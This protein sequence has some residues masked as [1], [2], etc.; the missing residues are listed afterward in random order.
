MEKR[1]YKP[2]T[3]KEIKTLERLYYSTPTHEIAQLLD[4]PWQSVSSAAKRLKLRKD[5]EY[6]T[7]GKA[8]PQIS[9][10]YRKHYKPTPKAALDNGRTL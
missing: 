9:P 4:R 8:N 6:R 2:Y 3:A 10:Q 7:W 1:K 5:P